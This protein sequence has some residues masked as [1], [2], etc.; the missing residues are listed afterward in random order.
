LLILLAAT[1]AASKEQFCLWCCNMHIFSF[2]LWH[3]LAACTQTLLRSISLADS[4]YLLLLVQLS[5][6]T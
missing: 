2:M 6:Q 3:H 5:L 4:A 1:A